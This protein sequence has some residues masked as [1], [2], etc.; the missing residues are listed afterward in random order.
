MSPPH[1]EITASDPVEKILLDRW[2]EVRKIF[3][4]NLQVDMQ[5][6][7][8]AHE[9]GRIQPVRINI[10]MY[11]NAGIV[12]RADSITEV[13]NYDLVYAGVQDLVEGRHINLQETLAGEIASMCLDFE[14]VLAVRISTE[15]TDIYPVVDGVGYELVRMRPG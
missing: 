4:R 12:P 3:F 6:G 13:F 9:K 15:K 2:P 14:E 11:M 10:V 5:I 1:S 7:V 8:H